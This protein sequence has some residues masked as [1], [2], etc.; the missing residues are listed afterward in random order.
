MIKPFEELARALTKFLDEYRA[1]IKSESDIS[2]LLLYTSMRFLNIDEDAKARIIEDK[3]SWKQYFQVRLNG[4]DI[5]LMIEKLQLEQIIEH[6]ENA[7]KGDY[8]DWS[9]RGINEPQTKA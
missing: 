3:D 5:S 4:K 7:I 8:T 9:V 6:I 2:K 1:Q